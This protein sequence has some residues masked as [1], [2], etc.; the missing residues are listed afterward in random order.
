MQDLLNRKAGLSDA[1]RALLEKRL[2]GQAPAVRRREIV[3]RSAGE[4]PEFPLS[5]AQERMWFL[6]QMD[7]GSPMYNV[8]VAISIR[9]DVDVPM[10]ER[11]VTEVVRRHEALRTVYRMVD[12]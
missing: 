12:G 8:P 6:A 1:K 2:R 4:G 10:L 7:P 5:F 3:T 9:A 11:A